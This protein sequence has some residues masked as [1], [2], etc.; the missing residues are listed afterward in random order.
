[1]RLR[2]TQASAVRDKLAALLDLANLSWQLRIELIEIK[3][4]KI[5][6]LAIAM[7][8]LI[9]Q[10][11]AALAQT[12]NQTLTQKIAQTNNQK[13][14]CDA[15]T[16]SVRCV[17]DDVQITPNGSP[18][19]AEPGWSLWFDNSRRQ[20]AD[21][22]AGFSNLELGGYMEFEAVCQRDTGLKPNEVEY[23]FRLN[24]SLMEIGTGQVEFG[25]W[26]NHR[27]VHRFTSTAI[28]RSLENVTCL[29]V[30]SNVG[31]GLIVRS[32]PGFDSQRLGVVANNS[33]V[34]PT[35]YPAVIVSANDRDWINIAAP[36]AGWISNGSPLSKGNLR[37][38]G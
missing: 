13:Y 26:R 23:W 37:L 20:D 4:A 7:P 11:Q 28:R 30:D 22:D 12:L 15:S 14:T 21:F 10:P 36:I 6:T 17:S 35:S 18:I 29:R 38:C 19:R 32:Q 1:M 33:E 8:L 16:G 25:C 3:T 9:T 24:N 31:N 2:L 27:F 5:A 34:K